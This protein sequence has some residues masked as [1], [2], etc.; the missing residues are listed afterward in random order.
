[1]RVL[2][3]LMLM[4][5]ATA[6]LVGPALVAAQD[7][8]AAGQRPTV[9]PPTF[10]DRVKREFFEDAL[11]ELSGERPNYGAS[12]SGTALADAGDS[13]G[14]VA[15]ATGDGFAW[16]TLISSDT[17]E[18][19]IKSAVTPLGEAVA[20]PGKFKAGEHKP[21]RRLYSVVAVMFG[22]IAGYD[23]DVKW[24]DKAAALR[25][26]MAKAGV[27]CKVGTD[28]SF[29]EAKDRQEELAELL[30]GGA[31]EVPEPA[32]FS[33]WAQASDRS[34]LMQRMEM[35]HKGNLLPHTSSAGDF[36]ANADKVLH[37]AQI[38]AALAHVIQDPSF[39]F[40]DDTGYQE[41]AHAV[42][43]GAAAV[44]QAA[45]AGDYAKAQHAMAE[46]GKACDECHGGFR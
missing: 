28:Q 20:A 16:S 6:L 25:D 14:S 12:G 9:P 2:R 41:Y 7:G 4:A 35:A 24:K 8:P 37:E 34:P 1:M 33:G 21:A 43:A 40:A 10:D 26:Q 23:G 45:A 22:V 29:K 11:A 30:R 13:G 31:V 3:S 44:A 19:E 32:D 15:A 36:S 18:A 46:I 27:N 5:A 17:I 38:L 42:E 39:E